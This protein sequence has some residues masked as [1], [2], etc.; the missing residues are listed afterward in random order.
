PGAPLRR[1]PGYPG[2]AAAGGAAPLAAPALRI[3]G[4][5]AAAGGGGRS[6]SVGALPGV[7]LLDA[8]GVDAP[9][10]GG[11]GPSPAGDPPLSPAAGGPPAPPHQRPLL[12][13]AGA[14]G[15]A[16]RQAARPDHAPAPTPHGPLSGR[17]AV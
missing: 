16:L 1:H 6:G 13:A 14:P 11:A 9:G 5:R 3:R 17:R 8:A 2:G 7:S 4:L 15:G 12:A 10:R